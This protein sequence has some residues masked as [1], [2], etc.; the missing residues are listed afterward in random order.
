M[1]EGAAGY[2]CQ[3]QGQPAGDERQ[4]PTAPATQQET[5]DE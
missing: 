3:Q 1:T 4:V 5:F 2:G